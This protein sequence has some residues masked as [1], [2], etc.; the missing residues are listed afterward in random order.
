[1]PSAP[2]HAAQTA[3]KLAS[4]LTKSGLATFAGSA[5]AGAGASAFAAGAAVAVASG[6]FTS[7]AKLEI[8]VM[9]NKAAV[10]RV[11]SV[12]IKGFISRF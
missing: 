9:A 1:M 8:E 5:L 6:A 10:M 12:E 11:V 3:V 2:W 4:P 7:A